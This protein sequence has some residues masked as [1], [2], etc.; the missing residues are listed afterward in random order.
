M[1]NISKNTSIKSLGLLKLKKI[2]Y[3]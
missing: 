1:N 3:C 2:R